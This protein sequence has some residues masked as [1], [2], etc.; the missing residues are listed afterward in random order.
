MRVFAPDTLV[1][2]RLFS[3]LKSIQI[4]GKYLTSKYTSDEGWSYDGDA[5][6]GTLTLNG[7]NIT[8]GQANNANIYIGI[9]VTI[10]L[11]GENKLSG[12]QMGISAMS[13]ITI[14]GD[15]KLSAEGQQFGIQAQQGLIISGNADITASGGTIGIQVDNSQPLS[16]TG[17]TVYASGGSAVGIYAFRSEVTISGSEVTA[18]GTNNA[19]GIS[20]TALSISDNSTVTFTG[21]NLGTQCASIEITDS[22]VTA[23]G[24]QDIGLYATDNITIHSGTTDATGAKGALLANGSIT[25]DEGMNVKTPALGRVSD[26]GK[27]I[28]QEDGTTKATYV[29][30]TETAPEFT[31]HQLI[32]SGQIGMH[33]Y[34]IIPEGMTGGDM[35]FTVGSRTAAATGT[36]QKDGRYMFTCY[37]N[38]VEMAETITATYTYTADEGMKTVTDTT[39]VKEY[40]EKVIDNED[41]KAEYTAVAP[42][43]MAIYNYGHYVMEALPGGSK[44]PKMPGT[45]TSEL[46]LID[47]LDGYEISAKLDSSV[48]TAAS[49]SQDLDSETAINFYLTTQ[50]ELTEEDVSVT[51]YADFDYTVEKVGSRWRVRIT[52]IGAHELGTVFTMETGN[53][54]IEASAMTYVQQ[55]LANADAGDEAN[56]AAALYEYY[57]QAISYN[58]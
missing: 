23:T 51:A 2:I 42:L 13:P 17:S 9:P 32:L 37:V 7:A 27:S 44:H 25:L 20:A 19:I 30:I 10:V 48:I 52:G 34:M 11:E 22:N 50:S 12:Q 53:T 49:Y 46:P 28:V 40:L 41:G 18:V 21:K 29:V 38:S 45:Y 5:G 43:A 16:I 55:C 54:T 39:S 36:L 35:T 3:W 1:S 31:T 58:N 56:H 26:D 4:N 57:R 6:G 15:G 24:T 47:S 8:L 14:T 33:F